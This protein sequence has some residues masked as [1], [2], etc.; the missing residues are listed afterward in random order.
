MLCFQIK[1]EMKHLLKPSS[2]FLVAVM[3]L[4]AGR[5]SF[6]QT[7]GNEIIGTWLN[8]EK[9]AQ[10]EIDKSGTTYSGKI[11]WLKEPNDADTGKPRLDKHNPDA[12]L[13]SRPILGSE[14]LYGFVFDKGEKEWNKGTIY[15]GRDGKSYKCY[16]TLNT[17]GSLKVRGYVG[18]AWMGLGKTNT[19]T[20]K[21]N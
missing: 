14:L 2:A 4:L 20:R 12:K 10:I 9:E 8:Q 7:T 3:L 19:W 11:V 1:K 21:T 18:A 17:D 6:G 13:K 15:D 5:H 16:I